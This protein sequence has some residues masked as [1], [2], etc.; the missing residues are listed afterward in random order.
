MWR[1]SCAWNPRALEMETEGS[2]FQ[3]GIA[4]NYIV[5]S[6]PAW[7]T[8]DTISKTYNKQKGLGKVTHL[9]PAWAVSWGVLLFCFA[10]RQDN[11]AHAGL[12]FV[13]WP[14]MTRPPDLA[15]PPRCYSFA[16]PSLMSLGQGLTQQS[17]WPGT[18]VCVKFKP[19]T[20]GTYLKEVPI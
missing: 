3:G 1:L 16:W 17:G 4:L 14:K 9:W 6:G 10:L 11:V 18:Q 15:Y 7:A 8:L 5:S 2:E 13:M 20:K 19:G 12:K